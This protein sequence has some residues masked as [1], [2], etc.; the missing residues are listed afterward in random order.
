LHYILP[1]DLF[2]FYRNHWVLAIVDRPGASVE[3]KLLI[4][5]KGKQKEIQDD[6]IGDDSPSDSSED[7]GD[8]SD[9]PRVTGRDDDHDEA[10]T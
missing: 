8:D 5:D 1:I 3:N 6:D 7:G 9:G 4:N 2:N 10:Q